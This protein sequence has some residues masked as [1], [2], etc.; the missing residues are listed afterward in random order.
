MGLWNVSFFLA[1]EAEKRPI[2]NSPAISFLIDF[3]P[4]RALCEKNQ[5][6]LNES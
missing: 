5:L 6:G 2:T 3:L 1:R 4:P